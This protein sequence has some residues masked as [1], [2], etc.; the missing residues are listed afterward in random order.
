[1]TPTLVEII[2]VVA[3]FPLVRIDPFENMLGFIG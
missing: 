2:W 3:L 1:M